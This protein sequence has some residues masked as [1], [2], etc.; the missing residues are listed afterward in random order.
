MKTLK[1]QNC[2][3]PGGVVP[4]S[5]K[6]PS[7]SFFTYFYPPDSPEG[8]VL[9]V[10]TDYKLGYFFREVLIPKSILLFMK[11]AIKYQYENSVEEVQESEGEEEKE[12]EN[13]EP[14][15]GPEKDPNTVECS[16]EESRLNII[17][18]FL[19]YTCHSLKFSE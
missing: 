18:P 17:Q 3:G 1:L 15:E 8:R 9:D 10:A 7:S 12:A 19:P 5:R 14:E 16:L 13:E 6:V 2:E 4:T 11:E